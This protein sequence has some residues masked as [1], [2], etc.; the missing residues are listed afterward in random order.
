M[1]IVFKTHHFLIIYWVTVVYQILYIYKWMKSCP[2][3]HFLMG[4]ALDMLQGK[5]DSTYI[6]E[7]GRGFGDPKGHTQDRNTFAMEGRFC[8]MSGSLLC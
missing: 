6:G 7:V 1:I 5:L 3:A 2:S 4:R 8:Y